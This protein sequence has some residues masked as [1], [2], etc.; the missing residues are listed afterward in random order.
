SSR[1]F[2]RLPCWHQGISL[3]RLLT[4]GREACPEA[5]GLHFHDAAVI[6]PRIGHHHP[7]LRRRY[8]VGKCKLDQSLVVARDMAT[9]YGHPGSA[10]GA[11]RTKGGAGGGI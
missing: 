6:V 3:L 1:N 8:R 2:S 10:D 4:Y 7:H 11:V 5:H 9:G